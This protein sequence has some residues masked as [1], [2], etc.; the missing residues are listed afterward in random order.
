MAAGSQAIKSELV[1]ALVKAGTVK[2]ST[3]YNHFDRC[4]EIVQLTAGYQGTSFST[5]SEQSS[6]QIEA[7]PVIM[8]ETVSVNET[9]ESEPKESQVNVAPVRNPAKTSS[10]TRPSSVVNKDTWR[11][12]QDACWIR[13]A[14]S[15]A[16]AKCRK[17]KQQQP[18]GDVDLVK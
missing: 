6:Q 2:R 4:L 7:T 1:N 13:E 17:A 14:W 9:S 18:A 16:V 5:V 15:M 11:A 12:W 10:Q 8:S 3:A